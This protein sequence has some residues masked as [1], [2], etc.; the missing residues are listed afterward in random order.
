M[1]PPKDSIPA[2]QPP[3]ALERLNKSGFPLQS[4]LARAISSDPALQAQGWSV[5]AEE[6]PWESGSL[7]A[8]RS[9]FVDLVLYNAAGRFRV[10]VE[11]K[12]WLEEQVFVTP[13]DRGHSCKTMTGAWAQSTRHEFIGDDLLGPDVVWASVGLGPS[14]K[15]V[16]VCLARENSQGRQPRL[17]EEEARELLDATAAL[18]MDEATAITA[19]NHKTPSPSSWHI[20]M[21]VTSAPLVLLSLNRDKVPLD[22]KSITSSAVASESVDWL[23]FEKPLAWSPGIPAQ[24]D[25]LELGL[26]TAQ[27]VRSLLIVRTSYLC[28]FLR[29]V[30]LITP[31]PDPRHLP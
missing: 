16:S 12:R 7:A 30:A 11:C 3:T 1:K 23:L 25:A 31:R 8:H 9:G 19:L 6:V 14:A 2:K 4:A 29:Q 28:A 22:G 20:P 24:G 17:L 13:S 5:E 26:R 21:L 27:R 10:V 18:A 15:T